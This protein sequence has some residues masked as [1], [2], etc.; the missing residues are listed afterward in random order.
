MAIIWTKK[1]RRAMKQ[2][3]KVMARET[4]DVTVENA[5]FRR[6]LDKA[7]VDG[8][9]GVITTSIDC[10]CT[11]G[12]YERVETMPNCVAAIKRLADNFYEGLEGPGNMQFVRP[13][14]IDRS[15]SNTR[16]LALEAFEDGHPHVV[17]A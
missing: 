3:A 9:I 5:G 7:W 8:K 1:A 4:Y 13:D 10:D 15:R 6:Q 14:Q 12:Y 17:Y 11:R 16:D 2:L